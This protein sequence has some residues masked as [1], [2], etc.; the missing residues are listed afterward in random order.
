MLDL[1][2]IEGCSNIHS[3][4][5]DGTEY[6]DPNYYPDFQN[7]L[8]EFK[9]KISDKVEKKEGFV[10]MR[11][12]DGEFHFLQGKKVGNVG[13]R[14]CSIKLSRKFLEPFKE[15]CYKVDMIS[16]QMNKNM[17]NFFK[18]VLP[19]LKISIPMDIIYG[20][21]TN[22][23]FLKTF[24]NRIALIGGIKKLD[25]IKNLMKYEE[26]RN[27]IEN[28]YFLDY[29]SVPE[30]YSC[31]NCLEWIE[32]VGEK[33]KNSQASIFLYGIGISKM[34]ISYRFKEYKNAVFIDI[35]CGLSGLAG[36]CGTDRPYFGNWINYRMKDY[37]YSGMDPMDFNNKNTKYLS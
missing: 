7:K 5:L 9:K 2:K 29:I 27:Y 20:L 10:V 12:Y 14:H 11:V 19:N 8:E 21:F 3:E 23:W 15:G 26:Y 1:Y 31:D 34:A 16:V 35:G 6:N 17:E 4:Q 32:E 37:D 36:T 33:I 18:K 22:K 25:V 24:K 13:R 28:D 30:I